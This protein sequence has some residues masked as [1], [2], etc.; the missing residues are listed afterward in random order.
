V[1]GSLAIRVTFR[2]HSDDRNLDRRLVETVDRK[3]VAGSGVAG[4]HLWLPSVSL[5]FE[6]RLLLL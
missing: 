6:V 3:S 4:I 5:G 1:S 2:Y